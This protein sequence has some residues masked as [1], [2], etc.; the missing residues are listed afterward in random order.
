MARSMDSMG[1]S[2]QFGEKIDR[3]PRMHMMA[4]CSSEKFSQHLS[5]CNVELYGLPCLSAMGEA[6]LLYTV[7][8]MVPIPPAAEKT[9]GEK[10]P[11]STSRTLSSYALFFSS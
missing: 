3:E 11:C 2:E 9:S 6:T 1:A 5:Q 7:V 8:A 4:D 10:E